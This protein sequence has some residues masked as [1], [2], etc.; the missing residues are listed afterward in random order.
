MKA[1]K[2]AIPLKT[3][4]VR[5]P[6]KN[7]RPFYGK[8]S[9]FDIKA[10]QLL[11]VFAPE[12][13]YVSSENPD[14][15]RIVGQ[16]GFNFLLRDEALTRCTAVETQIVSSIVNDIP[17]KSDI[18][19]V[20]V[21][22][23]LFNEFEALLDLYHCLDAKY[24]SIAVVKRFRHHLLD[25][26]GN[27]VNFNFGYWHRISQDLPPLYEV[28][29]AAFIM[30]REMLEQAWY[31]IGRMPYLYETDIPLV[32]IDTETDFTVAGLLYAHYHKTGTRCKE[33]TA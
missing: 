30:R 9:L 26:G 25:A 4:S 15:E 29:W 27:P 3:N 14:V 28:T 18:M 12:D 10:E 33:V 17:G 16:Y 11:Q 7:L 23:P 6:N 20:Q 2:V 24:D 19:W 21:T 8:K 5:V 13:I 32:D 22:Q 1:I 31:Q